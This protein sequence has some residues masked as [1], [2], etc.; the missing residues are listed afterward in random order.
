MAKNWE[1]DKAVTVWLSQLASRTVENYKSDFPT[2]LKYIGMSPSEQVQKRIKDLQSDEV[3][4]RRFFERKLT[5]WKKDL[6]KKYRES[7][8]KSRMRTTQSFFKYNGLPLSLTSVESKVQSVMQDTTIEVP[9]N[10]QIRA[11]YSIASKWFRCAM[12]ISYQS[13]FDSQDTANLKIEDIGQLVS[14]EHKFV[15]IKRGKT[16]VK[17]YTCLSVE[18]IHDLLSTLKLRGSPKN[19]YLLTTVHKRPFTTE[20]LNKEFKR[21]S[22]QA[23]G[24]A[25]TF[26]SLRKAFK[27]EMN[28]S[29]IGDDEIKRTLIG[30]SIGVESHYSMWKDNPEPIIEGYQKMF[31]NL[32][33]NGFRQKREDVQAMKKELGIYKNLVTALFGKDKIEGILRQQGMTKSEIDEF[34]AS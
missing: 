5:Q 21:L 30:H 33:I 12:L 6:E 8:V 10:E 29:K 13:G 26:K 2:W 3:I 7:T 27:R 25:F 18:C 24:K 11:T 31:Q 19:G 9:S 22:K 1:T 16:G 34:M 15:I 32:S 14:G 23:T 20:Q 17:T 28:K 4:T